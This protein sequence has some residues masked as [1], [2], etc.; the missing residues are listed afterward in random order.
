MYALMD[1]TYK[2]FYPPDDVW[3]KNSFLSIAKCPVKR[4]A[5]TPLEHLSIEFFQDW[6]D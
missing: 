1:K 2:F 6:A 5:A 3:Y 4:P